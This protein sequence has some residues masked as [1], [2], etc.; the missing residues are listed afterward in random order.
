M[1]QLTALGTYIFA[2]GFSLGVSKHFKVLAHFEDGTFGTEAVR[3]NMPDIDIFMDPQTWPAAEYK[4]RVDF[5]FANPPCA[6]FSMA[7]V[8]PLRNRDYD[9]SDKWRQDPRV[10]CIYNAYEL[11]HQI[12]PTV[13]AFESVQGAYKR[14]RELIDELTRGALKL[15]YSATH[16]LFDGID[17]GT[18]QHRRRFFCVFHKVEIPWTY[19]LDHPHPDGFKRSDRWPTVREV[20]GHFPSPDPADVM[21]LSGL[22]DLIS[23]TRPGEGFRTAWERRQCERYGP[24]E[25]WPKNKNGHFKGRPSFSMHRLAWD[26]IPPT[27]IGGCHQAHPEEDRWLSWQ[28]AAALGGYP[29]DYVFPVS[30]DQKFVIMYRAVLP[31][32]GEWLA[33]NVRASIEAGRP[34]R[35][36]VWSRDFE[37]NL[38]RRMA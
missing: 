7:G 16:V 11:L 30:L 20:I 13:W 38:H 28:E 8:Q 36:E 26:M 6:P 3:A 18:P 12:R 24:R 29:P 31:A 19:P 27:H 10:S 1:N 15:G 32:A 33:R 2:G 37:K 14:G 23:I 34:T 25:N 35:G 9:H 17:V 22:E 4:G 5:V 21:P